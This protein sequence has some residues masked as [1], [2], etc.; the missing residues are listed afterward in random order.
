MKLLLLLLLGVSEG[1]SSDECDDSGLDV[2]VK[3]EMSQRHSTTAHYYYYYYYYNYY[4]SYSYNYY[5]S[6]TSAARITASSSSSSTVQCR[7]SSAT[8]CCS[9]AGSKLLP[10]LEAV[11]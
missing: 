6:T 1:C 11:L 2:H 5:M 9:P 3:T 7:I 4:Y 10:S 8:A